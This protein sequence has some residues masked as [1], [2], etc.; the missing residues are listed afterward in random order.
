MRDLSL[1]RKIEHDPRSRA[2]PVRT[3]PAGEPLIR[4]VTHRR[5]G[6]VLD[7]GS[8]GACTG[9]AMAHSLNT[10]PVNIAGDT[11]AN[12]RSTYRE[13]EALDLYA[14]ATTLDQWPGEYRLDGSGQDT[15]SS[16]LAAC[17]AAKQKGYISEYRWAFGFPAFL[18]ALMSG[19]VMVGTWWYEAM[20]T[21]DQMHVVR[22][23]GGKAGGHEYVAIG[24]HY[25]DRTEYRN[26]LLTFQN[27]WGR[28]WGDRGRFHMTFGDFALL[29]QDQGDAVVPIRRTW[30]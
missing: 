26:S 8:V 3:V 16:G 24:V 22:P 9:F 14:T 10:R 13:F 1:G 30:P 28:G 23:A 15:G 12:G 21:P 18:T 6:P 2:F 27:S 17:K 4:R 19:P 5:Y 25:L 11:L 29:L 7:Q 20:F